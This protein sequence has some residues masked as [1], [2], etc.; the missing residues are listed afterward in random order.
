MASNVNG[1]DEATDTSAKDPSYGISCGLNAI[2]LV[3]FRSLYLSEVSD[4]YPT[5]I[6]VLVRLTV[7]A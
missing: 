2:E 3:A 6:A 1:S 4:D 5:A 7:P